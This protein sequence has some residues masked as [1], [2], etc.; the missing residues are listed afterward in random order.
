MSS[1]LENENLAQ[2]IKRRNEV[3]IFLAGLNFW[4]GLFDN[5]N[6]K[7]IKNILSFHIV[8]SN[9]ILMTII[10]P[11][12]LSSEK[13]AILKEKEEVLR[14][15]ANDHS[16]IIEFCYVKGRTIGELYNSFNKIYKKTFFYRKRFIWASNYFNCFLGALIKQRIPHTYLHF[17]MMGLAPEEELLYSESNIVSRIIKFLTLKIIVPD[18]FEKSRLYIR[19]FKAV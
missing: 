7:F 2:N 18:K 8:K 17:E 6:I 5:S 15:I 4:E 12:H 13:L 1:L 11:Y 16:T 3:F 14:K 19:C 10:T 9:Y